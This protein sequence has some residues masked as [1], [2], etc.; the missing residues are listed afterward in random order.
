VWWAF[1]DPASAVATGNR[2]RIKRPSAIMSTAVSMTP[3]ESP[4]RFSEIRW[5]R[6]ARPA[7]GSIAMACTLDE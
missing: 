7:V 3:K 5:F 1:N 6:A 4:S 2:V